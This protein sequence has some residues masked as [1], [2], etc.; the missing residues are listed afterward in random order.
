MFDASLRSE[1]SIIYAGEV[2]QRMPPLREPFDVLTFS[3]GAKPVK[4][5]LP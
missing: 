2:N 5:C 4:S 3:T 1:V